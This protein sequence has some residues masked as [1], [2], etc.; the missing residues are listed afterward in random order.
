MKIASRP[1]TIAR[2]PRPSAKAA[3]M[4]AMPR[5]WPAASGFRPIAPADRPAR[6]PMPM[7]G[8][9]TPR[10]AR[11]APMCSMFEIP[12]GGSIAV[13]GLV[14][15]TRFAVG[16]LAVGRRGA[17]HGLENLL[18]DVALL[19]VMALDRQDDEHQRQDAE[20]QGLD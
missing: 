12:P 18:R 14:G 1:T 11:P 16:C 5:I 19:F 20:D 10:A 6:M 2:T 8:P 9:M 13:V 3:R 7:P 15:L 4:I 17:S